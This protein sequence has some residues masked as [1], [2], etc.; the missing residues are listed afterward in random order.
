MAKEIKVTGK[1]LL[2]SQLEVTMDLEKSTSGDFQ[3]SH[4]FTR[5]VGMNAQDFSVNSKERI[6]QEKLTYI[7]KPLNNDIC[8][9][10]D[11]LVGSYGI[12]GAPGSGKT[13]LMKG[14]L[15]QIFELNKNDSGKKYGAIILDPKAALISDIESMLDKIGRSD[16]LIVLNT[17][18][19]QG[20]NKKINL[21]GA[22]IQPNEIGELLV[23][24]ALSAGSVASDPFWVNSWRNLF[25]AVTTIISA[26]NPQRSITLKDILDSIYENVPEFEDDVLG[27]SNKKPKL[28]QKI[29][30]DLIN[31]ELDE[32]TKRTVKG[33]KTMID[34][35]FSQKEDSIS[36]IY[37]IITSA[38]SNFL[39]YPDEYECFS[40]SGSK[41]HPNSNI[42]DQIIEKGKII[43]VSISPDNLTVAKNVCTLAKL[44]FQ[45]SV[46]SRLTRNNEGKISNFERPLLLACDEYDKI[47]SELPGMEG[48]GEFFSISRQNG[49]M[50]LIA[51][52]SIHMLQSSSLKENWRAVFS[53]LAAR[54]FMRTVDNETAEEGSNQAGD[55]DYITI[56][57]GSNFSAGGLSTG[58]NQSIVVKKNIPGF[59]F[60]NILTQGKGVFIGSLN[61]NKDTGTY[62]FQTPKLD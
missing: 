55:S 18:K 34:V 13:Y 51:T 10:N 9:E 19:L 48:D 22:D 43:L 46:R 11:G 23:R 39:L 4:D 40:F 58:T 3:K 20:A 38:Y 56:S 15:K 14:L 28:I 47:A 57:E 29:A 62:I 49:C 1:I 7:L 59:I 27:H 60:T 37:S 5:P 12:F 45:R 36:T 17:K 33:A 44:L 24:A 30:F 54:I 53:T 35:F 50:G 6:R 42:Y 61:G 41:N 16:D 52:Q 2:G 8:I 25:S 21:I 26:A 32:S 31:S